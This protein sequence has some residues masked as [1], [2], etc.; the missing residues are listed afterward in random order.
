MLEQLS[1]Q[2]ALC[3]A[4]CTQGRCQPSCGSPRWGQGWPR[5][6]H[7]V[8]RPLLSATRL[9]SPSAAG[10]RLTRN[11]LPGQSLGWRQ[12][13]GLSHGAQGHTCHPSTTLWARKEA[14]SGRFQYLSSTDSGPFGW[15]CRAGGGYND[16]ESGTRGGLGRSRTRDIHRG[17]S[18]AAQN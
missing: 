16:R 1:Q 14:P 10:F 7:S 4:Y 11:Y 6:G 12:Q 15:G 17:G 18:L 13:R 8:P 5:E 2:R 9:P 3:S